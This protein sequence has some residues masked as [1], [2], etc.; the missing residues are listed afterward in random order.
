MKKIINYFKTKKEKKDFQN[1]VKTENFDTRKNKEGVWIQISSFLS[2][3][4]FY[5]KEIIIP[6]QCNG[7]KNT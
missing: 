3:I 7:I 4:T 1:F 2:S 6:H 5:E